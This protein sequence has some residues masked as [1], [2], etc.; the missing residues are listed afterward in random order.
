M[1]FAFRKAVLL[2]GVF[3]VEVLLVVDLFVV[4]VAADVPVVALMMLLGAM[5]GGV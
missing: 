3:F 1:C 4:E 2:V 5:V